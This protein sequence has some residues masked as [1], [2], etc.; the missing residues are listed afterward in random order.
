MNRTITLL[1]L[2]ASIVASNG[3]SASANQHR[4]AGELFAF[5]CGPDNIEDITTSNFFS[6]AIPHAPSQ[7]FVSSR[8][9][10]SEDCRGDETA[11]ANWVRINEPFSSLQMDYSDSLPD[12]LFVTFYGVD[13]HNNPLSPLSLEEG[14]TYS[15]KFPPS[16][17]SPIAGYKRVTFTPHTTAT[18]FQGKSNIPLGVFSRIT[19]IVVYIFNSDGTGG[20]CQKGGTSLAVGNLIL[21]GKIMP[22]RFNMT[23]QGCPDTNLLYNLP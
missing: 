23:T 10:E 22:A 5:T 13:A 6:Q 15:S 12:G 18:D 1:A 4:E 11:G 19:E 9:L 8:V 16:T 17:T 21:N 3:L 20:N 2:A 7:Q 14:R